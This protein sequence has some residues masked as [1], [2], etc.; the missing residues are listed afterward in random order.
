MGW[1]PPQHRGAVPQVWGDPAFRSFFPESG[2]G[3]GPGAAPWPP[4]TEP[5]SQEPGG[6]H[7]TEQGGYR[8]PPAPE[9]ASFPPPYPARRSPPSPPQEPTPPQGDTPPE[10]GPGSQYHSSPGETRVPGGEGEGSSNTPPQYP[11]YPQYP[12][13][14]P[15]GEEG[16]P[17]QEPQDFSCERREEGGAHYREQ[18]AGSYDIIRNMTEKYGGGEVREAVQGF[19]TRRSNLESVLSKMNRTAEV[20]G[21]EGMEARQ[22]EGERGE[23]NKAALQGYCGP[24]EE[25]DVGGLDMKPRSPQLQMPIKLRIAGGEVVA[26]TVL[27]GELEPIRVKQEQVRVK[28]EAVSS[29]GVEEGETR[30]REP[31]YYLDREVLTALYHSIQTEHGLKSRVSD[32]V[33]EDVLGIFG[34]AVIEAENSRETRVDNKNVVFLYYAV[35]NSTQL[36][37]GSL[38]KAELEPLSNLA[39][40]LPLL[41]RLLYF[42]SSDPGPG[43]VKEQLEQE[44]GAGELAWLQGV[45]RESQRRG[46]EFLQGGA[47]L[48]PRAVSLYHAARNSVLGQAFKRMASLNAK[49]EAILIRTTSSEDPAYNTALSKLHDLVAAPWSQQVIAAEAMKFDFQFLGTVYTFWRKVISQR[50]IKQDKKAKKTK[51]KLDLSRIESLEKP[52]RS[53]RIRDEVITYDEDIIQSCVVRGAFQGSDVKGEC[54]VKQ[55]P[56][57]EVDEAD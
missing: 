54:E 9:M 46:E 40:S 37:L 35:K 32:I 43:G 24:M 41:S 33:G 23:E 27:D 14:S 55:E 11:A 44:L 26:N 18:T 17:P 38:N 36:D 47:D 13:Y 21:M 2:E 4:G 56:A 53:S 19:E 10:G 20:E 52:K 16:A 49:T 45:V 30:Y 31:H 1:L 28:T 51:L 3:G 5:K 15:R 42:I 57:E 48:A 29:P 22:E 7:S 39:L 8:G 34:E 12:G 25:G 50:A 6:P